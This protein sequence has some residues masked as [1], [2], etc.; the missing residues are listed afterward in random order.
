MNIYDK[1]LLLV[2]SGPSGTGK[3]T[4]VAKILEKNNNVKLSVSATT[5][6][7]REKE[8][9]GVHYFFITKD[10]FLKKIGSGEMLEYAEYSKNFYGTPQKAVVDNLENG[11][12]VI[13]EIE[14]V[15]AA[16]IKKSYPDAVHVLILPPDFK[17]LESR[18][19]GRNTN[20]EEDIQRRL[21]QAKN[22]IQN[23]NSYDYVVINED[24]QVDRVA[25]QIL[26]IM[27]CE[28][29]KTFRNQNMPSDFFA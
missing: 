4:V 15:G 20:T 11:V 7:P 26:S 21:A 10:E 23:F 19:R 14:V 12:N 28:R 1:G 27:E 25:D 13:L 29:H 9:D 5:R 16:Q 3:G 22:E 8:I 18:L 2:L 6:A 17:T 24:G